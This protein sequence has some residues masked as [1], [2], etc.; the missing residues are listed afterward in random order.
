MNGYLSI[1]VL[2]LP[3][4]ESREH[5]VLPLAAQRYTDAVLAAG[6]DTHC[7]ALFAIDEHLDRAFV[8]KDA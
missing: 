4:V 1:D 5:G 6:I 3:C 7:N 2:H 8:N